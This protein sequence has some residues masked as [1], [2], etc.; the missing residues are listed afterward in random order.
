MKHLII[1]LISFFIAWSS[2][3]AQDGP[4]VG[5]PAF[6]FPEENNLNLANLVTEVVIDLLQNSGRYTVI[7]MT[8]EEQRQAA[9]DR[10]QE[11]YK[12]ENWIDA[13]SALNPELILGGEITSIKFVKSNSSTKPG[14]RAAISFTLKLIEVESS[15]ITASDQFSSVRS[16]LRLTPETALTSAI[17]SLRPDILNF[18]ETHIKQDFPVIRINDFKKERVLSITAQIPQNLALRKGDKLKIIHMEKIGDQMVP[19]IIGEAVVKTLISGDYWNLDVKSGGD[20]M[21]MLKDDLT[22]IRCSE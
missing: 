22:N 11:N 4:R 14:Y 19:S 17:E 20:R 7:D 12:A 16:E 2:L 1:G 8:S 6:D 15:K 3:Y 13:Y 18:F 9:L 21:F 5:V 10:A